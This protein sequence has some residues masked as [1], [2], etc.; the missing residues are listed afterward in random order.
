MFVYLAVLE[1]LIRGFRPLLSRFML[2]PGAV[3]LVGGESQRFS[4]GD[5]TITLT[6][7]GATVVV[8]VYVA[9][10]VAVALVMLRARDV[11]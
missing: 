8:A 10:L 1:S 5:T 11:N 2:G 9:A 6:T 4:N 7:G 3:V